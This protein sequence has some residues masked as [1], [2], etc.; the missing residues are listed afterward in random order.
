MTGEK[1]DADQI[2]ADYHAAFL[3]ANPGRNPPQIT[4]R[5]GGWWGVRSSGSAYVSP[6]RLRDIVAMTERL[7][8]RT[9]P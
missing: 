2:I 8:E 5:P 3:G 7:R 6:K 9:G 1:V 4:K